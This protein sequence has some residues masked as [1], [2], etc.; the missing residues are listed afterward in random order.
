MSQRWQSTPK[1]PRVST[2]RPYVG[3]IA[4]LDDYDYDFFFR[5][6]ELPAL[7]LY[8][9]I[10]VDPASQRYILPIFSPEQHVRG[11]VLRSAWSGAPRAAYW[12][13]KAD[14]YMLKHEPVQSF[15]AGLGTSAPYPLI[16]VEDQLSAI[17]VATAGYDS[18]ALL[19]TPWSKD[20]NGYQGAD[21]I[22]EIAHVAGD[23][24]LIVALD[25]DATEAAFEFARKW[26]YAFKRLRVA[27]LSKDL[28]D[29]PIAEFGEVLGV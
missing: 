4:E 10:K 18:V 23:R 28:K 20:L 26:R 7:K 25:A 15:Y 11:H 3:D 1:G 27:I 12:G 9:L 2:L 16:A 21:R 13:P 8:R 22:A 19:G 24:E 17:K 29:T 5:K 6:Y 14:T